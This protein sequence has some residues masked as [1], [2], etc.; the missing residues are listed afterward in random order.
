MPNRPFVIEDSSVE[1]ESDPA[2]GIS[3]R[4]LT[5]A[6]RRP[7]AELTSGVA[8]IEPGGMLPLHRHSQTE[9]YYVIEGQGEVTLDGEQQAVGPGAMVYIPGDTPHAFRNAGTATLRFFYVFPTDSYTDVEYV[10][11]TAAGGR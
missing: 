11:L 2:D 4:T 9:I 6:D 5:S 1:L 7:S 10:M 8:Y 3:W